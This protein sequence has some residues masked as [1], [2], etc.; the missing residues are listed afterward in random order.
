VRA[1]FVGAVLIAVAV[2]G[3]IALIRYLTDRGN[4]GPQRTRN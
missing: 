3:A 2:I 1:T 4:R